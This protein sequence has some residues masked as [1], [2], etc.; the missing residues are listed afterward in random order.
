MTKARKRSNLP[1]GMRKRTRWNKTHY[2]YD[3]GGKPRREIPLGSDY[4]EA[5]RKWAEMQ[6]DARMPSVTLQQAAQ[7]YLK[8]EL[9]DKAKRYQE[10]IIKDLKFLLEFFEGAPLEEIEP[11]NIKQYLTW[12]VEVA[13]KWLKDRNRE[14]TPRTGHVRANREVALFSTIFNSARERGITTAT[15]PTQ[16]VKKYAEKSRE[17][18]V[19]DDAYQA[20]WNVAT[21]PLRDAMDLAYL[22]GQR[23]SDLVRLTEHDIKDGYL[24]VQQGKTEHKVRIEITDELAAVIER[25]RERRRRYKVMSTHLIVNINGHPV[26]IHA[27]SGWLKEA[28][29]KAG[30]E[31][32]FRDLRAKAGT[33]KA[34]FAKD[35]RQAQKQ[36]GHKRVTTTEHYLRNRRGE[37]VSPTR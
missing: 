26:K 24:S 10:D 30:V 16:G 37:K 25:I 7:A 27:V 19:E 2:Y 13:R 5:V 14:V 36:L 9:H 8:N 32:Q 20:V 28:R 3:I 4:L 34:D 29:E 33:D 31:F 17:I 6:G 18:Y 35:V 1:P 23:P 15:N 11:V 22:T 21:E 12:R